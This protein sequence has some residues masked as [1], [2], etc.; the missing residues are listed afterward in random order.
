M[1]NENQI[2]FHSVSKYAEIMC[3]CTRFSSERFPIKNL[4][5]KNDDLQNWICDSMGDDYVGGSLSDYYK[6]SRFS[7][8]FSL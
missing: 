8:K 7:S 5:E 4:C 3:V 1:A 6:I 2:Q